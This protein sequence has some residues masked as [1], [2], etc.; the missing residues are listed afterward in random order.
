[1]DR[2]IIIVLLCTLLFS[3][4]AFQTNPIADMIAQKSRLTKTGLNG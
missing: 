1:M 2:F 4:F 3:A